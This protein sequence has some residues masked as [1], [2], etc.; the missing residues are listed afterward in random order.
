MMDK[1]KVNLGTVQETLLITLWARAVEASQDDPIVKD[2]KSA[3]IVNQIDCDFSKLAKAKASQVG[4]CLRGLALDLWV[5]SF[6]EEYPTGI[7]VEIGAGLNTRFERVDNGKVRWFD[8]D[9]PDSMEV[10]RRFFDETDRR[11]FI[12]ASVLDSSW[13]NLVKP[14]VETP[15]LF[16]AEGVLMYLTEAQVKQVFALLIEHFPGSLFAFDSMSPFMVKNQKQHDVMKY[17]SA[18]FKWGIQDIQTIE[19]WNPEY[20]VLEIKRFQDL[21][22]KYVRRMGAINNFI[23]RI[24]PFKNMYRLSLAKLG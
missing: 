8:L 6:L 9:L 5:T 21:P 13:V 15:V 16:V 23:F 12:A 10:R 14:T 4:I 18:K 11:K 3:E 7:V 22:S 19:Q 2:T 24:P 17:Y 20:K 1:T